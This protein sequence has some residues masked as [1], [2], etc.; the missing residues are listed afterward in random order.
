MDNQKYGIWYKGD[1]L[2]NR[3]ADWCKEEDNTVILFDTKEKATE[4][5]EEAKLHDPLALKYEHYEPRIYGATASGQKIIALRIRSSKLFTS[6]SGHWKGI[7]NLTVALI[8]FDR[9]GQP[10]DWRAYSGFVESVRLDGRFD[11]SAS[12]IAKYG[13]KLLRE[14][15]MQLAGNYSLHHLGILRTLQEIVYDT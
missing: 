15:A 11:E 14:E 10:I 9:E 5:I 3:S 2:I 6:T 4:F 1:A 8:T 12:M 7:T 13:D